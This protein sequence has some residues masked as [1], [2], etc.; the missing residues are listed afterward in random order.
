MKHSIIVLL[1][2]L[3]SQNNLIN[4]CGGEDYDWDGSR[5]C[6]LEP[7]YFNYYNF[8]P[9][10]YNLYSIQ[11]NEYIS[12]SD[13]E[14]A[15]ID[16]AI[17]SNVEFWYSK[18]N[19]LA[20]KNDIYN[21]LYINNN[22]NINQNTSNTFV[23][24]LIKKKDNESIRYLGLCKKCSRLNTFLRDPWERNEY[25]N[26]PQ[27][28]EII[29]IALEKANSLKDEDL[30]LRY[31]FMAIRL[32]YYNQDFKL[33]K[34]IYA[35]VFENRKNKSIID[36]WSMYFRSFA[37]DDQSLQNYYA[38]QVFL[39][40]P[41][42]RFMIQKRYSKYV[43]L[44]E[45]LM[46]AFTDKE[47]AAV[48]FIDG[49]C[50]PLRTLENLK[51]IY[52]YDPQSEGFSFLLLRE[53]NKIEDWIFSDLYNNSYNSYKSG[54]YPAK[55]S[56]L[57]SKSYA[58]ELLAFLKTIERKNLENP[59]LVRIGIAYLYYII[60]D[61]SA[62]IK[63][64]KDVK[65]L[66][67]SD[68]KNLEDALDLINGLALLCSQQAGQAI[69]PDQ[70]KQLIL[71]EY[72]KKNYKFIFA[73]SRELE[74]RGNLIDATLLLS[75]INEDG[76]YEN[77]IYWNKNR[78][79]HFSNTF[80]DYYKF[81]EWIYSSNQLKEVIT[82]I[83]NNTSKG[84]FNVWKYSTV[85]GEISRLHELLGT[86]Y[87]R[88]NNLKAALASFEKV[89]DTLWKHEGYY[90]KDYIKHSPFYP[91]FIAHK[92]LKADT[93]SYTKTMIVR[94]LIDYLQKAEDVTNPNRDLYYFLVANCYFNMTYYGNSWMMR[95]YYW[96]IRRRV[97]DFADEE[98]FYSCNE[99]KK[100]YLKAL[101]LSKKKK[102][103]ALCLRMI[104]ICEDNRY[105]Y[106]NTK[107]DYSEPMLPAAPENQYYKELKQKYR[108]YYKDLISNCEAF[109]K[110][111]LARR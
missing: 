70:V 99:A 13:Y 25:A 28:N 22:E 12:S 100:Y 95:R 83:E 51:M 91:K 101:S 98:E 23:Q 48:Y 14:L 24:Y 19:K 93:I 42:K 57:I 108:S 20:S 84:S 103:S 40:A 31:A 56:E 52:N 6:I 27:R 68:D 29:K 53:I 34:K 65:K 33:I 60:D 58:R 18:C 111:F 7:A 26:L 75:K 55:E 41:D 66:L 104:G 46:H 87:I 107:Y 97:S 94:Q 85:K 10:N 32:S 4:A 1:L 45:T 15:K 5:F 8:K 96:S 109:G 21:E 36:Y 35:D 37:E 43:K 76:Y 105:V 80:K 69:I 62:A 17:S 78:G 50:K 2:L 59:K 30:R 82:N 81:I 71:E 63:E 54:E 64:I 9:F 3:S 74:I 90:F 67:G 38:A 49:V 110:Y 92:K 77:W 86:F 106:L 79:K 88:E 102:F 39:Y 72:K 44:N 61:Y 47:K 73:I 89:S 11:P 16:P